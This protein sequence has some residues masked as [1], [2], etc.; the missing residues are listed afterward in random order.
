MMPRKGKSTKT[1]QRAREEDVILNF[2]IFLGFQKDEYFFL[3]GGGGVGFDETGY[4]LGPSN[5][6]ITF[7]SY[8]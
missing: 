3:L 7:G 2:N 1:L 5:N 6:W 4:F 8:F